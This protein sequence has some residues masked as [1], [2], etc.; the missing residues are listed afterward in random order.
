MFRSADVFLNGEFVFHHEE[1]YTP[2]IVWLHNASAPVRTGGATNV[3]A[4]FVNGLASELWSY[5]GM[6]I[7]R[8]VWLAGAPAVSV[9]PWSL[10]APSQITGAIHGR[11]LEPQTADGALLSPQVDIANAGDAA[12]AGTVTFTLVDASGATVCEVQSP[13]NVTPGGWQR[14]SAQVACGS[15]ASPVRLWN[16][17][18][19]GAFLHNVTAT[20]TSSSGSTLDAVS[21]RIGLRAA[22]FTAADG[23]TL[24]GEKLSLRGFSNHVGFGGCGGAVPDRVLEFQ[25]TLLQRVGGNSLR[26]AH[27]P[28]AR[29]FLDLADEYGVLVWE[30]NRFIQMGVQPVSRGGAR[31]DAS[32]SA[33][34]SVSASVSASASASASANDA[35]L[36]VSDPRLLQDAQDMVLRDRNHPSIIIWSLCNELG[37]VADNPQGHII[38]AQFKNKIYAADNSRP[39]TG[40]IVQRPY[41]SGRLLD[42]FGLAM[43]VTAFSHQVENVPAYRAINQQKSVGL[44]ESGSCTFDRGEYAGSANRSDGHLGFDAGIIECITTD[45]NS[46]ATPYSFGL[47]S[48]TLNDYLGETYPTGWPAVS[49]H[50]GL[51]DLA[52]FAKDSAGFYSAVWSQES[53]GCAGIT[54][55]NSDWTAPVAEGV[56]L[57]VAAFTCSPSAELFLNG[58]SLGVVPTVGGGAS[59]WRVPFA[60]GNLTALARDASGA[61]LGSA[62]L[63]SAGPPARLRLWVEDSYRPPRNGTVIAAD[64]ADV[65]VLGVAVEDADG[66]LCPRGAFNVSFSIVGPAQ[67]YG[68]A[69]GDPADHS[70]VK[71]TPWRLSFHGLSRAIISSTGAAGDIFVTASAAGVSESTVHL[72]A[73]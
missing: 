20:L 67:I 72:V 13:F 51:F 32:A 12:S 3:L 14:V 71:S 40:N 17:A 29:E 10:F 36:P 24:N 33:S 18:P 57:D 47:Y 26:T 58:V 54:I 19:A 48:W 1:G 34:A 22:A 41:L 63:L 60:P 23:F 69:N 61:A 35:P 25:L 31:G 46:I 64:G 43:D 44:G 52:G 27:N 37:C 70:P 9:A 2:F 73:A 56:Q 4:V 55:G 16:T 42:E 15:P 30:E 38:A 6:G 39:V 11:G 45:M 49:S 7:T 68:V 62:T 5:E 8:H 50:F 66:R 65:A 53:V 59:V 28:V 21:T